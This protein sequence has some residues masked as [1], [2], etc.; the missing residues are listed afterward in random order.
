MARA[1]EAPQTPRVSPSS[2]SG[3]ITFLFTDIEGSTQRWD[4]FGDAMRLAVE[5]HDEI[6]RREI[7]A[8]SGYVFKTVGDAFC[9]AFEIAAD[10]VAAAVA[11][12][13]ALASEDFTS[14]DGLRIR[15][16]LHAG[17][18][19]ERSGDYFGPEVNRVARL[20]AIGHGGQ[21]LVS[22]A[23]RERAQGRFP[24]GVTLVDLGMR[25][26]KDLTQPEQ[27]WQLSVAGLP[28][29]F[30]PLAS[31]DARANNLP[32]QPTALLGRERDLDEL[33]R[34]SDK[35]RLLS[36]TGSGG[37]G[38]TRVALQHG[39]DLLDR[40]AD[41]VWFADL[42]AIS[43]PE[44]VASV[45]ASALG[46]DQPQ[47]R[48]RVDELIPDLL[49]RKKLLLILDNCEHVLEPVAALV[50]AILR[51]APNVRIVA[52]TRQ[53]LGVDGE[54]TY[55]LP[56][57]SV[58]D[59]AAD[60]LAA[61]DAV[62]FGAVALF[63]ERARLGDHR[64]TLTD[65]N[66][67]A[68]IEICRRLDGIP[69]AIELAAA[70]VRVLSL[71]NLA[72][73]LDE[74][75]ALLTGGS[76]TAL[77]RQRTLTA[78]IDWSYDL[79]D[80]QE[81]RLFARLSVLAGGFGLDA[82]VHV[83]GGEGLDDGD[84]FDL[85]GS[86]ADKSLVVADT[87]GERERYHMLESTRAYAALKL[88]GAGD[89]DRAARMHAEYFRDLALAADQRWGRGPA[90]AWRSEVELDLDNYRAALRWGLTLGNDDAI[91][92]EIA[93]ILG[94][95]W[96]ASG[97]GAEGRYWITLALDKLSEAAHPGIVARL[98]RSYAHLLSAKAKVD[99][100]E[101]ALA[102]A[103]SLGDARGAGWNL[104]SLSFGALQMGRLEDA[105]AGC[106]RALQ[107]FQQVDD[108][109]GIGSVLQQR[110]SIADMRGDT[111]AA[112]DLIAQ[113]IA[114][115]KLLGNDT[116]IALALGNLGEIE[117]KEGRPAEAVRLASESLE[118]HRNGKDRHN[119]TL[120]CTNLGIYRIAL[121][122][123]EGARE[124]ARQGLSLA[125]EIRSPMFAVI[126]TQHLALA[127][128]LE[129]QIDRAARLRGYVDAQFEAQGI[130]R[131]I[132]ERWGYERLM[133][134]LREH[135]SDSQLE[136]CAAEGLS[137]SDDRAAEE[138]M[139]I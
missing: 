22:G 127:A 104:I 103:E 131:E 107:K 5:R 12:Q 56:S 49:T 7:E 81:Q 41:G 116:G 27:V 60:A 3:E 134:V 92:G 37:V 96:R 126:T 108:R 98:W 93:A 28:S 53:P 84:I 17:Q 54:A 4:R 80:E 122:D 132:T 136:A 15:T 20:M 94:R 117:F 133:A 43:D 87:A 97:L 23:V 110:A 58:P 25:R 79:L 89:R 78:L 73:R 40:F 39:A 48:R 120:A 34:L 61:A 70:R 35:H 72:R 121:G 10:A 13:R 62:E 2:P 55:R 1:G 137:W 138:A 71:P 57:L 99:A 38:K 50:H 29:V 32:V 113:A 100:A 51:A 91:G 83:C 88:A 16:G 95:M 111:S 77:P 130:Q 85:L 6:V 46:I 24:D 123:I 105:D 119:T 26:L 36:I 31:L 21:I 139:K 14:V 102:L 115:F 129:G 11:A 30:P 52:T 8:H 42:S 67:R 19:I 90:L 68:V 44:L 109:V 106:A 47:G 118:L 125:R 82:A 124:A 65:D 76:R 101:R 33:K 63:A 64:F 69:L 135:L 59:A 74:R 9:A 112:R 128:A 86:L 66:V 45:V 18:V 75:F 114:A